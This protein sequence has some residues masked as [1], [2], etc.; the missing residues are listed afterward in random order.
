MAGEGTQK[1]I[2]GQQQQKGNQ[3]KRAKQ[4]RKKDVVPPPCASPA[5]REDESS[6]IAESVTVLSQAPFCLSA[7]RPHLAAI[8]KKKNLGRLGQQAQPHS[9]NNNNTHKLRVCKRD[10]N[11]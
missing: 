7:E 2:A 3:E 1:E 11:S 6:A 10:V 9:N 4:K 8:K 5:K